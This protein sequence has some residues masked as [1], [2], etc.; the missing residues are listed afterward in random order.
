M[1]ENGKIIQNIKIAEDTY[2][3]KLETD[4]AYKAKAGQFI[5][6]EIPGFFLRRPLSIAMIDGP[7]LTIIYKVVGQG[8]AALKEIKA[9]TLSLLGPLGNGFPLLDEARVLIIGGGIGLPPL[10]ELARQY[11]KKGSEVTV[12]AGFQTSSQLIL[13]DEF[14]ALGVKLYIATDDG[15]YGYHGNVLA[16]IDHYKISDDFVLACGPLPMLRAID[17]RYERGYY[18][19]EQRMACGVG[20]CMGCVC[21]GKD[22][23]T[24][25]V[26]KDG[27]VFPLGKVEL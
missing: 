6:I 1:L 16:L 17:K 8:T 9:G 11:L 2:E 3:L 18:S 21:K 23:K 13:E 12:V 20:A 14:K 10:Y 4:L 26:C 5:N 15:S 19:L 22:G 27:P 25:R 7:I 24:Y